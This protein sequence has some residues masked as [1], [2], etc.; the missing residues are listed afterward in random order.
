VVGQQ[1]RVPLDEQVEGMVGQVG[2]FDDAVGGAG[3]DPEGSGVANSLVVV[4]VGA[5]AA[6]KER[7]EP[8]LVFQ[9]DPVPQRR[10]G[11][12]LFVAY[13]G[14]TGALEVLMEAAAQG[15]RPHLGP[16]TDAQGGQAVLCG[17][18]SGEEL[19]RV[20]RRVHLSQPGVRFFSEVG[21]VDV[22]AAGK[23]EAVQSCQD[24]SELLGGLRGQH[25]DG[26]AVFFQRLPVRLAGAPDR[27]DVD[28]AAAAGLAGD[29]DKRHAPRYNAGVS[30]GMPSPPRPQFV[31][32]L[33]DLLERVPTP[34]YAYDLER[35]G[36][37]A[38]LYRSAFRGAR[39]FYA[40]K[41]NPRLRLLERL[42]VRGF[43]AETVSVGEV[44]RSYAA[45]YM[46]E[47]VVLNG[48]VKTPAAL[49]ELERSG[50][51][52]LVA[53]SAADLERIARILPGAGVLLR[54]NPD[55]PV[56][57][58]PHLATGRGDSQFGVVPGEWPEVF[59]RGRALGLVMRG[60]HVHLGSNLNN[61]ADFAARLEVLDRLRERV[62]RLGVLNLGGG[63][64]LGLDPASL[65]PAMF[66]QARAYRAELWIEPGRALIADAGVLVA[67][68]WAEKRTRR[69]YLLLDAGMTAF[70]RPL[71][72]GARH[73]VLP[74]YSGGR[75][76]VF[77][78]AG[79]ACESGD[80]LA[81]DVELPAPRIG[82]ALAFLWAGAY[83]SAMSFNYLDHPRPGEY[84]WN[85]E[86]WEVW[87]RPESLSALWRDEPDQ[88]EYL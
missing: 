39:I 59:E 62:E 3:Q 50:A 74:L 80:V 46:P 52:T 18:A 17:P 12:G 31:E 34:F 44:L 68:I 78:L 87:R 48:P 55:L 79:P 10:G 19:E 33:K 67:R 88:P 43:G 23:D 35:V 20:A 85:G 70:L 41:A 38:R 82:D 61:P 14:E 25:H 2:G 69:R 24:A 15:D 45:G 71:L 9:L 77:D 51:P 63:F 37:Q 22:G 29:T 84:A 81:R 28:P 42:R 53:D 47:E 64:G 26:G 27:G 32:A 86:R 40:L 30:Y 8:A 13:L 1:F 16:A 11:G 54:L 6:S 5:E 49:A 66:S 56:D 21:G 73:Q 72:Y 7:C 75:R 60:L 36:T 65:A 83:G 58:H 4:A 76:A 57:T